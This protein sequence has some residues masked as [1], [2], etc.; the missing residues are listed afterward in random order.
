MKMANKQILLESFIEWVDS[1]KTEIRGGVVM[2][3]VKGHYK[4]LT[5]SELFNYYAKINP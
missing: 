2:Y 4:W 3:D 1:L 5:Q